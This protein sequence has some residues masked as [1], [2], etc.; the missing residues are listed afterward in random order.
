MWFPQNPKV[1][2]VDDEYKEVEPLLSFFSKNGVPYVYFDGGIDSVP[3][4]PFSSVRLVIL[5]IDLKNRTAGQNDKSKASS[6]AGYLNELIKIKQS[7]YAIL[8]WT[9]HEDVICFVIDYLKKNGGAP[10]TYKNMEKP[11]SKDITPEYVKEKLLSD[12][13]DDSFEFL[14]KWEDNNTNEVSRFTNELS[15]VIVE[16]ALETSTS[17]SDRSGRAHV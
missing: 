15:K 12:L 14:L 8:F 2:V 3:D 1:L 17:W 6:L 4:E 16:E 11:I 13:N 5:D 7:S 9:K 10:V